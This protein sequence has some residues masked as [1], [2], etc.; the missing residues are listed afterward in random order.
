MMSSSA[1]E[2]LDVWAED[3]LQ[4]PV[5]QSNFVNIC[6]TPAADLE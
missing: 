4:T 6:S 5:S 3:F 1:C 2:D